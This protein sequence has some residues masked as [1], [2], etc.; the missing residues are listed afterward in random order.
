MAEVGDDVL[1]SGTRLE[2]NEGVR[3][4]WVGGFLQDVEYC[5]A[6]WIGNLAW[7]REERRRR[8]DVHGCVKVASPDSSAAC[9]CGFGFK[10]DD[11]AVG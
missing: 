10:V 5:Y 11:L 9:T 2:E 4:V 7:W 3:F 8:K 6:G 1:E